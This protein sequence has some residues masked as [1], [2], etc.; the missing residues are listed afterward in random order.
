MKYPIDSWEAK[1]MVKSLPPWNIYSEVNER[2]SASA[3]PRNSFN[4]CG[5]K[6]EVKD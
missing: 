5:K 6:N 1:N 2:T 3:E 4:L